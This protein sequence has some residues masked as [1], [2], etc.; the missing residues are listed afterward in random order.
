MRKPLSIKR[1]S[2]VL[3]GI[4][5]AGAT[6]GAVAATPASAAPLPT[7][8]ATVTAE[9]L[10]TWQLNGVVWSTVVVGNTA[11]VTGEFSK[12]RPPGTSTGDPAEIAASNIFAFDVTTGNPVVFSHSLNAQGLIIRAS[13]DGTRLYVGGDFTTVDDVPRA[14]IASFDL[15]Q[16]GAPLTGMNARTDG[17]VR[18]LVPIGNT[19][20]AGGNFRSAN[21]QV[22]SLFAAYD[23]TTGN[24]NSW[25]PV[26]DTTGYVFTMVAA[27]DKSRIIAGGS[28]ATINGVDA[29]G[30]GSIDANTGETLPWTA[31]T[32][33]RAAGDY[34]AI[35]TLST[36]G[37]SIFG[38]GYSFGAGAAFEGTFSANPATGA[39]NWVND[40]LGDT[41]DTFPMG[42][43]LYTVSHDHNCTLAGAFPD[44][45]PRARWQK[46]S[47][48][49]IGPTIGTITQKDAYNWDYTGIPYTGQL[50]WYP[51]LKF[52]TYTSSKQAAWSI[53]GN[54]DYLVMA[55]EFPTVN[56]VAQQALTRFAKAPISAGV[57][58][59]ASAGS[60]PTPIPTGGGNVRVLFG[61]MFDRDDAATDYD[62]F[63]GVGA[64]T[65]KIATIT[66][67]DA[68]FWNLPTY[69]F[70][71]TGQA[72]GSQVRYQIRARD[73]AG[74][75]QWS[76]WSAFVTVT[77]S[78]SAYATTLAG[79]GATHL[80][81]VGEAAG[82]TLVVD[83]IGSAHGTP[84][85]GETLG[86]SGAL[87]NDT[88]TAMT[89]TASGQVITTT[90]E[91][92]PS[93]LSVEA[94]V[95]TT[96][97]RGGRIVGFGDQV[98]TSSASTITDRVLYLDTSGRPNFMINDS[99][100]RTVTART[101]IND[102]NWHHVVGTVDSSG[103][104]LFVDGLRVARDQRYTTPRSYT[105]YWR[106]G[107][108]TTTSFTNR[109]SD[110]A[111]AGTIDEVAVTPRALTLA[112]VQSHYTASGRTGS[113]TAAPTDA[114]AA[115]VLA[116]SPDLY[117]R[118]G[119][120]SGNAVDSS[121]A[122]NYGNPVTAG[123]TRP[124]AGA[125]S[126]DTAATFNGTSGTVIAQQPWQ[127][128]TAFTA[129]VW[130]KT[131]TTKG[132]K[133]IGF[134]NTASGLSSSNDRSVYMLNTGKLAF[135]T[136]PG[137]QQIVTSPLAYNDNQWHHAAA[138]QGADGM[139]LYVDG[140]LVGTNPTTTGQ[141][142]TGYWRVGGDTIWSGA[143]SRYLAGSLDEAAVYPTALAYDD[144]R[145]HYTASGRT[146][147]N[148][149]P[150]AAFTS[151]KSF[152]TASVDASTSSDPD[153]P[154]ADYAW[155][156]GDG[157]TATGVTASHTY[158][159][160]GTYT[161]TLTVTDAQGA[162]NA[163]TKS[164]IAA[165]NV[166]PTAAFSSVVTLHDVA[167]DGSGSSDPDGTLA[168]FAWDFGDGNNGTGA[169]AT[170]TYAAAG[171]YTV[172]LT[173]TDDQGATNQVQHTVEAVDPPNQLPTAVF[174]STATDL[175]ATFSAAASSDPDGT[176]VG[177]AW[178]FGDN[179]TGSGAHATHSYVAAGTY[180]VSLTVTDNRGGTN[181]LTKDVTVLAPN[182]LPTAAFSWSAAKA[183]AS[184]DAGA[185]VDPDGTI[186]SYA[187]AFG[188]G[189]TGDG[190]TTSHT[191]A[192][193]GT[194]TVTL[195][196]TD[197]RGGQD[198]KTKDVTVVANAK[199]TAAFTSSANFLALSFD[200]TGSADTDGTVD[201]YAWDFGDGGTASTA[202]P[203]HTY[204]AAGTYTVK[205][206]V[207]DSDGATDSVTK[208]VSVTTP[209]PLAQDAFG[210]TVATGWGTADT[211]GAWTIAAGS[212]R[213]SVADGKGKVS[214]ATAGSGYTALLNSV[215]TT[216]SDLSFDVTMDK[217]ATGG[218][219][220]F[221]A[222]GRNV[223]GVGFYSAKVRVLSTGAV[224]IY[225]LKTVGGTET[226]FSNQTVSGLTYA[227]G[228]TLKVRLQVA[229]NGTTTLKVKLWG[230]GTEPGSWNLSTTDSTAA[231]QASGAVGLSTYVSGSSTNMPIV[232]SF[233]NMQVP[234][235]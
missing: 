155:N 40:C 211:G 60:T 13:D 6:F 227:A 135:G 139:K 177:W 215:S 220:Y 58:P 138:T 9:A 214:M 222:I 172:T 27:P 168:T 52:G 23:T 53:G 114:Y 144:I 86:V 29:Y 32:R 100:M 162:T 171:T 163:T 14:H 66:K 20:Y 50:H 202:S 103:I 99:A 44:T 189:S 48:E 196:V 204:A 106:L 80:W 154:V 30:M 234:A 182:Q 16:A 129:E 45:N 109:P 226:I 233:D 145:A 55:G 56:G 120:S 156:F 25:A 181:T 147:P 59:I 26:G 143:T 218:G 33:L 61:A 70:T 187:W 67:N 231:L 174:S 210:R 150:V 134:G 116:N 72:I 157:T 229:G 17:Q 113:W 34:G 125:L 207:T 37:A 43:A 108:D 205:L 206:T 7:D 87:L 166:A 39:I 161:I 217:A 12:A 149:A 107:S 159:T 199:P 228:D 124:V 69:T 195:T 179:A 90:A 193:G 84:N 73:A 221:S 93:T 224:Q 184:F 62:I 151:T 68:E 127:S 170:H 76:A 148:R 82:S 164:F 110:T 133:L 132:G 10:P 77:D 105:G 209:P 186:A 197:D 42:G 78:T 18:G 115:S 208:T 91:V 188:D 19:L 194:Y 35:T 36:D 75:F 216:T 94:W 89:G 8:P 21:G 213:F 119:E 54:G 169:T 219:Q 140:L 203:N 122:G 121:G 4:L 142:Y 88:N 185:S 178:D 167:F 83:G 123:I 63:R 38:A 200:G 126:A 176:L 225:L 191:Y 57:K 96:S 2:G 3:A 5:L 112:E 141:A 232:Y 79:Q 15:T 64:N 136:Y 97:S 41:Y 165:P 102:G 74:N 230:S 160:Q 49:R 146:A 190:A 22:R 47:A 81:R 104:Q 24:I 158:A 201:S 92:A 128:P 111:L 46:A 183:K 101:G 65:T 130:F 71:D 118:L 85:T 98:G 153:G 137:T 117:W 180:H 31:N 95:K 11:Y 192:A 175:D 235:P 152:M 223:T 198:V 173:V 1:L 131:N 212:S 28:F 51:D